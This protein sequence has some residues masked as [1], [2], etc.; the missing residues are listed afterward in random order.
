P[1][2][3][4]LATAD[5]AEVARRTHRLPA[6]YYDSDRRLPTEAFRSYAAPLVGELPPFSTI[7]DLPVVSS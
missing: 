5:L 1:Y 4:K 6:E 2:R 7:D 3:S